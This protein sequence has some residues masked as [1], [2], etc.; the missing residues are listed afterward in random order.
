[1]ETYGTRERESIESRNQAESVVSRVYESVK[2]LCTGQGD[3]RER[4]IVAV[5]LLLPLNTEQFPA[6]L[7]SDFL[8]VIEQS[9]KYEPNYEGRI[10][11]LEATMRRIK[12]STGQKIANK[13]FHIYSVI[14]DIRG[15]PL[16]EYRNPIE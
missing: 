15:F 10:G 8:W 7:R 1:M 6:S 14:Q 9:T 12:K 16:L 2:A 13:I 11:N 5:Q 3:V 4:L